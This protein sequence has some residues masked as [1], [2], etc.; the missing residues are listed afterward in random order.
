MLHVGFCCPW[1]C[2]AEPLPLLENSRVSGTF[3]RWRNKMAAAAE[4]KE[5]QRAVR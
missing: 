3:V 2:S 1:G 4:E 5:E